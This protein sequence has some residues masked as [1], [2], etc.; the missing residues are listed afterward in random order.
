MQPILF[1]SS[2]ITIHWYGVL[3]AGGFLA[4][5]IHWTWMGRRLGLPPGMGVE[6]C[7]WVIVGGVVGART[8]FVLANWSVF[9]EDPSL[10]LRFNRGGLIYYGGFLGASLAA[11][12]LAGIRRMPWRLMADFGISGVPL[13]HAIGRLGCFMNGCCYGALSDGWWAVRLGSDWRY[14][15]PLFEATLNLAVYV[16]LLQLMLKRH[17]Q[18]R[19][20]AMYLM[21]YPATRFGLEFLRG[22]ERL[23]GLW[24]NAAQELSLIF[25]AM[26]AA[27]WVLL[28]KQRHSARSH[29]CGI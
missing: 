7:V 5:A 3:F 8:A 17:R 22:D 10:I 21:L 9:S 15:V 25:I 26:G 18:G 6:L 4:A 29:G 20:F 19:V 1:E 2:W 23:T 11:L 24:L 13:G 28:P 14:P 27:L 16:V 12:L